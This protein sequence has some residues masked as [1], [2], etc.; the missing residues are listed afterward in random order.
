MFSGQ[1]PNRV[2]RIKEHKGKDFW[3]NVEIGKPDECWPWKRSR[4]DA[5]YGQ[6]WFMGRK[7]L[8]HRVAWILTIGVLGSSTCVLHTCDN[9][10]CC[11]PKHLFIGT[12]QDN[13]IDMFAKGR[14]KMPPRMLG[15]DNPKSKLTE[16]EVL[17]IRSLW[18]VRA[19]TQKELW[20]RYGI[21]R[22]TLQAILYRQSWR[23]I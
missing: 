17:E 2:D 12:Q 15:E 14:G 9:P 4:L 13:L 1:T 19:M 21:T 18:S 7:E 23:H 3:D 22:T 16:K 20:E 11:N 8:A 10:P 5:G 6:A